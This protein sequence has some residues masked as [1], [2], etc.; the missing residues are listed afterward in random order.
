M[1]YVCVGGDP[2]RMRIELESHT[3]VHAPRRL[4]FAYVTRNATYNIMMLLLTQQLRLAIQLNQII[5]KL[6]LL[7]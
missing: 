1:V 4:Q 5:I 3:Q 6:G 7:T 2:L